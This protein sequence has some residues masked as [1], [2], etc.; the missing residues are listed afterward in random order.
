MTVILV[1]PV[2]CESSHYLPVL[3]HGVPH[4][5]LP[6]LTQGHQLTPNEEQGVHRHIQTELPCKQASQMLCKN[7]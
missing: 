7:C 3:T 1:T 6:G 2:V 4:P 5:H